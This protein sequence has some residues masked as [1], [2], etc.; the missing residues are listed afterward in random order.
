MLVL[1]IMLVLTL[2]VLVLQLLQS[3]GLLT[4]NGAIRACRTLA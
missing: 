3:S 2:S 4:R 1:T